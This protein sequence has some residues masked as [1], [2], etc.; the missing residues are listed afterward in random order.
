[1]ILLGSGFTATRGTQPPDVPTPWF[2]ASATDATSRPTPAASITALKS[3]IVALE[4]LIVAPPFGP[5][6]PRSGRLRPRSL[7]LSGVSC[8]PLVATA[9][10]ARRGLRPPL[11]SLPP[12]TQCEPPDGRGLGPA[13][14]RRAS[15]SFRRHSRRRNAGRLPRALSRRAPMSAARERPDE[16]DD[17]P[18]LLVVELAV[19]RRHRGVLADGSASVLDRAEQVVVGHLVHQPLHGQVRDVRAE[20]LGLA[21]AILAMTAR[22]VSQEQLLAVRHVAGLAGLRLAEEGGRGP[23]KREAE[24]EE[25]SLGHEVPLGLHSMLA[26]PNEDRGVPT[27]RRA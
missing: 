22:A 23:G 1:M 14:P 17:V 27:T 25:E 16:R 26:F 6:C 2:S 9:A 7:L 13:R 4:N 20:G 15:R 11:R 18:D 3:V 10:W 24:H 12:G 19:P 8:T 5:M 21:A